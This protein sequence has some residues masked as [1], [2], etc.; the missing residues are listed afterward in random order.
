MM[1][2]WT[3]LSDDLTGLQAIAGEFARLGYRVGTGMSRLPAAAELQRFEVYGIDTA[4]RVLPGAEAEHRVAEAVGHLAAMGVDRIFKH[5]DSILQGHIG[6]ELRAVA[7]VRGTRPIVYVPA[8][9]GRRRVTQHGIQLEVD[10]RGSVV[11]GGLERDLRTCV[12]QGTGLATSVMTLTALHAGGASALMA[13][14]DCDVLIADAMTDHDIDLIVAAAHVAG[15][16]VLS[17]SVGLAAALARAALP[18]RRFAHPVLVVAGSLQEATQ[19]QVARL[20]ERPD[21]A[22]VSVTPAAAETAGGIGSLSRQ[23]RDILSRGLHCVVWTPSHDVARAGGNG[24]PSLTAKVLASLRTTLRALLDEVILDPGIP[25]GGLV[26]AGGTTA[27]LA[28]CDVLGISRFTGLAWM[29]E[30][31]TLAVAADG[32]RAGLSVVTKSGGWG[33]ASALCDAVDRIG[34]CRAPA[35]SSSSSTSSPESNCP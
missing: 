35:D 13:N 5:N 1:P 14:A 15:C 20:L 32:A 19:R 9:P 33:Q 29:C 6:L 25:L 2:L 22:G 26:V 28:L 11:A 31:M 10:E 8:C 30:G 24:Y 17:G 18:K 7:Q 16:R 12:A 27:D 3:I 23:V 34:N 4:S 21:C